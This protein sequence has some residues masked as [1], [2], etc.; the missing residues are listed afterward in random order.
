MK[1]FGILSYIKYSQIEDLGMISEFK[2]K[3]LNIVFVVS[4]ETEFNDI[5]RMR[6]LNQLSLIAPGKDYNCCFLNEELEVIDHYT[7]FSLFLFSMLLTSV[8]ILIGGLMRCLVE[9]LFFYIVNTVKKY[10]Y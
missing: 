6:V 9:V 3:F 1:L 5:F 8:Y 10:K 4:K 7:S 2:A